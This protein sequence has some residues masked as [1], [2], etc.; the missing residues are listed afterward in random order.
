MAH[1]AYIQSI[2]THTQH[3]KYRGTF[4]V[5]HSKYCD[6]FRALILIH[7]ITFK[8]LTLVLLCKHE[9]KHPLTQ[10]LHYWAGL[11]WDRIENTQTISQLFWSDNMHC[12]RFIAMN[13]YLWSLIHIFILIKHYSGLVLCCSTPPAKKTVVLRA[14]DH[15]KNPKFKGWQ[16]DLKNPKFK[17][18]KD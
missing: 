9:M 1:L 14:Q 7:S 18:E 17:G 12:Y 15:K 2:M 6:T 10:Q 13:P 4:R 16:W 5:L 8:A 3:Y 11:S